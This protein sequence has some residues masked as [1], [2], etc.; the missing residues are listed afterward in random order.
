MGK[1]S[2]KVGCV[3]NVM[4][5]IRYHWYVMRRLLFSCVSPA[6]SVSLRSRCGRVGAHAVGECIACVLIY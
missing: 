6:V 5:L 1:S 4:R 2:E 3:I